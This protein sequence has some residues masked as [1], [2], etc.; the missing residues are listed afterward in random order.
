MPV[1]HSRDA[2]RRGLFAPIAVRYGG[3]AM[4]LLEAIIRVF[5]AIGSVLV[6]QVRRISA[7]PAPRACDADQCSSGIHRGVSG[8]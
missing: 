5:T 3:N 7:Q 1:A 8:W 6:Y 4:K 2:P